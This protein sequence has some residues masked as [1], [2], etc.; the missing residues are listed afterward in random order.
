[1][2]EMRFDLGSQQTARPFCWSER[3]FR[4]PIVT[5]CDLQKPRIP[6]REGTQVCKLLAQ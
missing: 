6:P 1:M 2:F 3:S 5:K 4:Y